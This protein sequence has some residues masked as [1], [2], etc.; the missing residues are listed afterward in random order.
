MKVGQNVYGRD[1]QIWLGKG[2]I[3]TRRYIERLKELQI[4]TIYIDY[5]LLD[6][7][8]GNVIIEETR[9]EAVQHVK[10]LLLNISETKSGTINP[11]PKVYSTVESIVR[12]ALGNPDAMYNLMDI[13]AE[14]EYLFYHSVNVCILSVMTGVTLGWGKEKLT[15]LGM[16]ALLHDVGKVRVPPEIINK[17]GELTEKEFEEVK[18][19]TI[20]GEELLT[21]LPTSRII[22]R[23]HHE[24]KNGEGYP[25][26]L[27]DGD[28]PDVAQIVGMGDVYDALTADRIYRKA[29][30]PN[31]AF[32]M[33]SATGGFWFD[34]EIVRAFLYNIAAFPVGSI[35]RLTSGA[36]AL[37]L[38]NKPGGSLYPFVRLLVDENGKRIAPDEFWLYEAGLGVAK[39]LTHK[40]VLG[41]NVIP[42]VSA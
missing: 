31:E 27:S 30:Q 39:V 21:E 23:C 1:G 14:D 22:A 29:Y 5:G 3:L 13:R 11:S 15:E 34:Y 8:I 37:V 26:G 24:R 9:Y 38:K 16:G 6:V 20:Y 17:P 18:R 7:D 25:D 4:P 32:E 28:I 41:L 33:I 12:Q 19:H 36:V 40:E 42:Y 35:V 10:N 2:I